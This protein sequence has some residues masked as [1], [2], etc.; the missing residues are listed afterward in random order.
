MFKQTTDPPNKS[1]SQFRKYCI[2]CHKSNHFVLNC[3]GKKREGEKKRNAY[4]RSKSKAKTF[5]QYF[6]AY[7]NQFHPNEQLSSKPVKYSSRNSYDSRTRSISRNRCS[8]YRSSRFRSPSFSSNQ[9]RPLVLTVV[10]VIENSI[11]I[12]I[13]HVQKTL[14]F[15]TN[16]EAVDLLSRF[17]FSKTFAIVF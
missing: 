3:F 12:E 15:V 10:I 2:L 1:K 8:P 17:F 9:P 6:R 11:P 14:I 5:N 13:H 7:Q 4:S 16:E